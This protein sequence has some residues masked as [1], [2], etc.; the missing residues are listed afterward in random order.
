MKHQI[1]S[2]GAISFEV[3]NGEQE[4]AAVFEYLRKEGIDVPLAKVLG[5]AVRH[6]YT[7]RLTLAR[8]VVLL[9]SDLLGVLDTISNGYS[10]VNTPD[11]LASEIADL[12]KTLR[13]Q[14]INLQSLIFVYENLLVSNG[15]IRVS[16][17]DLI[18]S[19]VAK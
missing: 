18:F 8:R 17:A 3:S 19:G 12:R 15:S 11:N 1:R 5:G 4:S 13:Q 9:R 7:T 2:E 6:Y 10:V 14:E 16:L